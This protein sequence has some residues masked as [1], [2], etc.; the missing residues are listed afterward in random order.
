MPRCAFVARSDWLEVGFGLWSKLPDPERDFFLPRVKGDLV[1]F[2]EGP[3][4][5]ADLAMLGTLLLSELRVPVA[6]SWPG[7]C[8]EV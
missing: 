1:S 4:S 5:S 2:Y 3:A 7:S 6:A 8:G